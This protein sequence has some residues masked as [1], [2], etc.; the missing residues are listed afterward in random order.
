V[1]AIGGA[2]SGGARRAVGRRAGPA[3]GCATRWSDK[4]GSPQI[5]TFMGALQLQNAAKGVLITT[6]GFTKEASESAARA[7]GAIV[8]VDGRRLA[9]LMI[10]HG[11]GVTPRTIHL[12]RIDQ[13]YFDE[14]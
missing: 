3:S 11:V 4:V 13:D 14:E 1:A 7:R 2:A 9:S 12:P 5:Q 6:S 10:D 8:L